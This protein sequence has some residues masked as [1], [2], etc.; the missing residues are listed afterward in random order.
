MSYFHW[1]CLNRITLPASRFGAVAALCFALIAGLPLPAGSQSLPQTEGPYRFGPGDV[2][3]ITAFGHEDLSGRFR[4]SPE[5]AISYPL[6]GEIP[7]S[8]ST[9][10][11]VERQVGRLLAEQV[12]RVG[13]ISVEVSEYAPVF[14]LG[15]V[16][17]PGR[18]E[19]RPGMIALELLA[20]GG[21][22]RR[23][24]LT[25]DQDP[26]LQLIELEQRLHDLRLVRYGQAV[27][28]LRLL[29]EIAGRDFDGAAEPLDE[30]PLMAAQK[31]RILENE[32]AVFRVRA[33]VLANRERALVEQRDS[34]D[35]EIKALTESIE[36]H[37]QEL[38]ILNQELGTAHALV[39]KGLATQ[40][41]FLDLKREVSATKRNALELQS[42][43]ARAHQNQLA[44]DLRIEELHN[45]RS[46]DLALELRDLDLAI[47]RT[48]E[49]LSATSSTLSALRTRGA[50]ASTP[51][52][53]AIQFEVVRLVDGERRA[54]VIAES[55][56]LQP[57]DILQVRRL[58]GIALPPAGLTPSA[59][60]GSTP[61]SGTEV[62]AAAQ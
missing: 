14:V 31:K 26:T 53:A 41:R 13:R 34:Y 52:A 24:E 1:Q 15:D 50:A 25:P 3:E 49:Q 36:L 8:G 42:F 58:S 30:L 11:E 54:L 28:R 57:R 48:D 37:K 9:R 62:R 40:A 46:N 12:P 59:A 56:A 19:F 17:S 21:G 27:T 2:L 61:T 60:V 16:A 32:Q 29:A 18:Y 55:D 22:I 6:L 47:A 45:T 35:H 7:V 33:T 23:D 20:L 10:L 39:S 38:G 5:G 43:L 51:Q 44:V 4:V